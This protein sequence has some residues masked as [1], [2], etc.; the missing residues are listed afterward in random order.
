VQHKPATDA[1]LA[2]QGQAY[3]RQNCLACHGEA[4]RGSDKM[5][6]VA[7]QQTKYLDLTLRRYRAGSAVR[8]DPMMAVS[9]R[10]MTDADIQAVIAYV[11]AMP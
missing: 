5:A 4:G 11:S 1:A 3:Y 10:A 8:V 6:R 9:T 7:G 2:A